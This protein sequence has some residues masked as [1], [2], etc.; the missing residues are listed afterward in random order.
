[1]TAKVL[2]FFDANI[3]TTINKA[4]QFKTK[5]FARERAKFEH[6]E[7]Y[8]REIHRIQNPYCYIILCVIP[9]DLQDLRNDQRKR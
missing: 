8:E 1:L 3:C 6:D 9:Q 2:D 4:R 5:V 7:L